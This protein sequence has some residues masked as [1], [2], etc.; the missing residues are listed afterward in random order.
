[1]LASSAANSKIQ[2]NTIQKKVII[3]YPEYEAAV[4]SV[5]FYQFTT[6]GIP[7]TNGHSVVF[8]RMF[9]IR[10]VKISYITI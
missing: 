7:N 3:A 8:Y 6:H 2:Y 4:R 1:V 10:C 5:R 9:R